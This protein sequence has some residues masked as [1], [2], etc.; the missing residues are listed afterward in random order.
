M[1]NT[2]FTFA[3]S[4]R[5]NII[6]IYLYYVENVYNDDSIGKLLFE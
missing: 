1:E 6:Y 4:I 5:I 2:T 3:G